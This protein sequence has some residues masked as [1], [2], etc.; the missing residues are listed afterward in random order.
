MVSL[1][2]LLLSLMIDAK[3]ERDVAREDVSGAFL[4]GDMDDFV[5]L[6]MVRNAVDILC[7]VNPEFDK[8]VVTENRKR[9]IYL[10]LLKALYGCVKAALIWY[11]L[12]VTVLKGMGFKLNPYDKCVAN[13]VIEGTQCTVLWYVDDNKVS[14]VKPNVVTMVLDKIEKR[15]RKLRIT[16]G[17][18]HTFLGMDIDFIGDAKVKIAMMQYIIKCIEAYKL[19]NKETAATPAKNDLFT[20]DER[21][22]VLPSGRQLCTLRVRYRVENPVPPPLVRDL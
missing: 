22:A 16:R 21:G 18:Q 12:F 9:V 10:Q 2:A 7:K 5:I 19:R 20:V 4:H 1:E 8:Y 15:F 11:T 13:K 17:K 14:H 3:E 6:K